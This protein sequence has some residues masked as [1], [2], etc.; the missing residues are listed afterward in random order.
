MRF[1]K[2]EHPRVRYEVLSAF[3]TLSKV[4]EPK[5]QKYHEAVIPCLLGMI[6][7]PVQKVNVHASTAM[8]N[9][10]SGMTYD[11]TYKYL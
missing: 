5:M 9:F 7:D 4:F 6:D 3:T 8:I 1:A 10:M 2:H 11:Q